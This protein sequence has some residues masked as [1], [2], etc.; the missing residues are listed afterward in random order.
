V[1]AAR[2]A[3]CVSI[4]VRYSW[5]LGGG[6]PVTLAQIHDHAFDLYMGGHHED[7]PI[8]PRAARRCKRAIAREVSRWNRLADVSIEA[9]KT[10]ERFAESPRVSSAYSSAYSSADSSE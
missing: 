6:K 9:F 4:S 5:I 10:Q 8:T 3:S 2:V 1:D 7:R